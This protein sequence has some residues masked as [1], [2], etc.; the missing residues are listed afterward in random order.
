MEA[1]LTHPTLPAYGTLLPHLGGHFAAVLRDGTAGE[2]YA[3]IVAPEDMPT[4]MTWGPYGVDTPAT[5]RTDGFANT[6]E[7]ARGSIA[8]GGPIFIA[9]EACVF[10]KGAGHTDWYLPSL[11]ELST[12]VGTVPK[13]FSTEGWYWTSTQLSPFYAFVV[14]FEYGCS[15]WGF[16][17]DDHRVRAVRR[18]PLDLLNA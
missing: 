2:L 10:F 1:T 12:C 8:A 6:V 16:K 11:V 3:L 5:S 9:A 18:V 17:D 14:D 13:L 15:Y 4:R 7:L